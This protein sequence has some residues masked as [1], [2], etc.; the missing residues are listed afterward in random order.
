M[1]DLPVNSIEIE[2]NAHTDVDDHSTL[3]GNTGY[4][5]SAVITPSVNQWPKPKDIPEL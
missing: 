1:L 3:S 4:E 5:K 2:V